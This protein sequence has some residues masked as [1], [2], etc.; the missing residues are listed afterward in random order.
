MYIYIEQDTLYIYNFL[1]PDLD[2]LTLP[3]KFFLY[4]MNLCF[5]AFGS[6][7]VLSVI[8]PVEVFLLF[9][10]ISAVTCCHQQHLGSPASAALNT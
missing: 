3:K 6:M 5:Y 7:H 10:L 9:L 4:L 1:A 2:L 8:S